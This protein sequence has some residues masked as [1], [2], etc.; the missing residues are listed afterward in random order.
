MIAKITT[1]LTV[2]SLSPFFLTS[3]AGQSPS[4]TAYRVAPIPQIEGSIRVPEE[5]HSV[6]SRQ[7]L[8]SVAKFKYHNEQALSMAESAAKLIGSRSVV[9]ALNAEPYPAANLTVSV[10]WSPIP[11]KPPGASAPGTTSVQQLSISA[12]E[13]YFAPVLEK[14]VGGFELKSPPTAFPSPRPGSWMTF[15]ATPQLK[16]G[17]KFRVVQGICVFPDYASENLIVVTFQ[18]P[19]SDGAAYSNSL[20]IIKT[21]ISSLKIPQ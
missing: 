18:I 12:L 13:K 9:F 7:A 6:D 2:C 19:S 4:P 11:P 20:A 8:E 21:V 16:S 3:S 5:W 10:G 1:A 14:S 15:Y 17:E